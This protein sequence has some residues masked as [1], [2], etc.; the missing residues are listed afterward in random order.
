MAWCIVDDTKCLTRQPYF[1]AK[2]MNLIGSFTLGGS[3][4]GSYRGNTLQIRCFGFV[5]CPHQERTL[6]LRGCDAK[7]YTPFWRRRT[8]PGWARIH[9]LEN[10]HTRSSVIEILGKLSRFDAR[11]RK[12]NL[13][14]ICAQFAP[15]F[16]LSKMR[17]RA[18]LSTLPFWF[19]GICA[20]GIILAGTE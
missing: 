10:R 2:L 12:A 5:L 20:M 18:F 15:V 4:C 11:V 1:V 8:Q 3:I 7:T 9:A 17:T 13:G 19:S 14:V 6:R 16:L